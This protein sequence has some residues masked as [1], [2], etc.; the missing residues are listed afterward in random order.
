MTTLHP[1]R[2]YL[3]F[4]QQGHFMIQRCTVTGEHFF[5]PRIAAPRSGSTALEW[6]P[7]SGRGVVHAT[8]VVRPKPPAVPF[9][10]V[11]VELEEGPRLMSRV[12]G[13][14]PEQVCIGLPVQARVDL[15]GATATL[16]FDAANR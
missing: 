5:Y 10:V 12:E 7:A 16:V 15:S 3:A 1:E 13:M 14:P 8:T 4:L 9:N 11:L 6:V 2:D